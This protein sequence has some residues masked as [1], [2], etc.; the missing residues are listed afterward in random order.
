M[1]TVKN[2]KDL[3]VQFSDEQKCRDFL[4]Q[5]RWNGCPEC[6]YCKSNKWYSIENGKRFKCGN[7]ECHKKYSVT[8]GTIFHSSNIPLSTWFPAVYLVSNNKKGIS[9]CQLAK[10]L[11]V[12]QK[13]SW[14]MIN[15]IR[16]SLKDKKGNIL[17]NTV[18]VDELYYSTKSRKEE[19]KS[20]VKENRSP[21]A[22][23][24]MIVG[25]LERGGELKLK[26]AGKDTDKM[27]IS[28]II[29]D[30]V[31][32]SANLMTDGEGTYVSIGKHFA[33]HESVSH[34]IKEY[35]R[36][37]AH[38][39]S[40]EGAFG[41]FRRTIIGTYHKISPKHLERYCA[42]FE[43]RYNTKDI[44]DGERFENTLSR[45]ETKLSW[46]ELTKYNGL[47][48]ETIIEPALPPVSIS[49]Q[50]KK[51]SVAQILNGKVVATYTSI[52][53]AGEIT[54]IKKQ[55]ISRALRGKRN[56]TGGYQ[57]KYL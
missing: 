35:V 23:K 44:K 49:K 32:R 55:S 27:K 45:I 38:T 4:V 6:P 7:K 22:N 48:N 42:E 16:E 24:S 43:Y 9:S 20:G 15:R 2:L 57:W 39:N 21:F 3:M 13:T 11:G 40:I 56:T 26:V 36:G 19:R 51:V 1:A 14:F 47:T 34:T 18:E 31:D 25:L 29:F 17:M 33:S 37:N 41:L 52:V 10:H 53:E 30:N 8:V 12:C 50:G 5:Q 46:K 28:P 54:G